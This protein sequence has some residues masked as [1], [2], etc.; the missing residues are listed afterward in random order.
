MCNLKKILIIK[1]A[2]LGDVL[3]ST[4]FFSLLNKRGYTVDHLVDENCRII[5]KNNPFIDCVT[6]LDTKNKFKLFIQLIKLV[7]TRRY[8]AVFCFHRSNV[9][10]L[11]A[12]MIGKKVYG[13]DNR[14]SFLYTDSIRYEYQGINR[15]VQEY[16]L[17][18]KF[19]SQISKPE[20]LEF[21]PENTDIKHNLPD[22]YIV[23]NP[24][25]GVNQ[26]SEMK[27]RRWLPEYFNEVIEKLSL[28]VV[29]VGAGEVDVRIGKKITS[30]NAIN[31]INK[32]S[33][34]ET[35]LIIKN[36]LLYFGNDSSL[37][38]LAASQDVPTLGIFGPTQP[39]AANPIGQKQYFIASEAQCAPCYN[40]YEGIKGRAYTC[41]DN[42]CMKEIKSEKVYEKI[43]FIIKNHYGLEI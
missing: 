43:K 2:S 34:D 23:C 7:F 37:M 24:G 41:K 25:G 11:F 1:L 13:F 35:A 19:D 40:P 38:F 27:N 17:I 3:A 9:L 15:T 36:S 16:N 8:D 26:H 4:P 30:Q 31:L 5:T 6:E 14:V 22:R 39:E 28:P 18:K 29:L 32:M 20:K 12:R 21:Y 10:G 33:F 42:I